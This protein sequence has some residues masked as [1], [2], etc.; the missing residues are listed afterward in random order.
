MDEALF[1]IDEAGKAI[2]LLEGVSPGIWNLLAEPT[3]VAEAKAILKS[4]FPHV[5]PKR[6][7]R[8]VEDLFDDLEAA[9]LIRHA[10]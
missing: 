9:G 1:L 8:D 2:H 6:V 7:A 3:S 10:N 4:A 5:P